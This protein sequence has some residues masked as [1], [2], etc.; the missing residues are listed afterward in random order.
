MIGIST[1]RTEAATYVD[2][3]MLSSTPTPASA[4]DTI[5]ESIEKQCI[6][7]QSRI[8]SYQHELNRIQAENADIHHKRNVHK[9]EHGRDR[10]I[11]SASPDSMV[12]KQEDTE[13]DLS[14][15][16][17]RRHCR[18]MISSSAEMFKAYNVRSNK[19]MVW[20][21]GSKSERAV[22]NENGAAPREWLQ[23]LT[24]S[25]ASEPHGYDLSVKCR[26]FEM[27]FWATIGLSACR[28][29]LSSQFNNLTYTRN[30]EFTTSHHRIA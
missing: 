22:R 10:L 23:E 29:A 4:P 8:D 5:L 2:M 3:D 13:E 1:S 11:D 30:T 28:R 17:R 21:E 6:V 20:T 12:V 25:H 16:W 26:V 27:I 24:W 7:F 14:P 18:S 9:Q 19:L 15:D